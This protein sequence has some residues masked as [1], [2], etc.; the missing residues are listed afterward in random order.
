MDFDFG[1]IQESIGVSN[2][3]TSFPT[4]GK[5]VLLLDADYIP[6]TVGFC[7]KDYE[8]DSFLN[9]DKDILNKKKDHACWLIRDAMTK[10]KCDAV[11]FF[12]TDSA[13]NFRMN[14]TEHYK[15][16]RSSLEK[17]FFWQEIHD[18]L[19]SLD[20]VIISVRN[21]ADDMVSIYANEHYNKLE[22][23]GIPRTREMYD[24]W[25]NIVIGSKD[26]DVNQVFGNHVDLETGE[27][28]WVDELG[29]LLP[30]YVDKEVNDYEYIPQF[31][32]VKEYALVAT[33]EV[34]KRGV[35]KG[36]PKY[37]RAVVCVRQEPVRPKRVLKGKRTVQAIKSLKGTGTKFF[38]SQVLMGDPTDNYFG[39]Q[40]VG[41]TGAFNL[42]N[43]CTS[44]QECLDVVKSEYQRVHGDNWKEELLIQA[45]F[46][47]MQ[48]YID[49]LWEVPCE[50]N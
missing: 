27:I 33:G 7:S 40:G 42:I 3:V 14:L 4:E 44:E 18:W 16:Q 26:K 11:K 10:A 43:G 22:E 23:Q 20:G 41:A 47:Y 2:L 34:F 12:V 24:L 13:N 31:K 29:E 36:Q 17:P 50:I 25:C 1:E 19:W 8:Y 39:L 32:E 37:K 30:K 38:Y 28:Y 49:E 15:E 45:R 46:A 21:E 5:R 6:Y 9:G 35:Q 48:K